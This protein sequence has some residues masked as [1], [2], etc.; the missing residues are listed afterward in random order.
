[1]NFEKHFLCILLRRSAAL[2]AFVWLARIGRIINCGDNL[3]TRTST[4]TTTTSALERHLFGHICDWGKN[5]QGFNVKEN[6]RYFEK[7]WVL[8]D[9]PFQSI[10]ILWR[11]R[12]K[13]I[14]CDHFFAAERVRIASTINW[15]LSYQRYH[16][17]IIKTK[18]N[19]RINCSYLEWAGGKEHAWLL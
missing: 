13:P 5:L 10:T 16:H 3:C 4:T 12:V 17:Y 7:Y 11:S 19:N 1:M 15:R 2:V 9:N 18:N 14:N 6:T 8:F